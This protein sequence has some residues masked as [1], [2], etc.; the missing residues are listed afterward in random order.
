MSTAITLIVAP[1]PGVD[2]APR[3]FPCTPEGWAAA[4]VAAAELE[5][6][7][8]ASPR[9][10]WTGGAVAVLDGAGGGEVD[11]YGDLATEATLPAWLTPELLRGVAD[12]RRARGA[13]ADEED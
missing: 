3:R 9:L 1:R 11:I 5:A 7:Y 12:L 4:R 8:R 10:P 13:D 6:H 2:A